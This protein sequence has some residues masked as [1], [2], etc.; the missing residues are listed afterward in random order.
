MSTTRSFV[1]ALTRA[2]LAATAVL[3]VATTPASASISA[4]TAIARSTTWLAGQASAGYISTN[5]LSAS[6]G[7]SAQTALALSHTRA[8][9]VTGTKILRYL[10]THA[11]ALAASL[12]STSPGDLAV[13]ILAANAYGAPSR[14]FGGVNLVAQLTGSLQGPT[15]SQPGLY[16]SEDPTYDGTYR[17]GLTLAALRAVAAPIPTSAITWLRAQE[18]PNGAFSSDVVANPCSGLAANYEGPDSNSTAAAIVGLEAAKAAVPSATLAFLRRDASAS[19]GWGFYPGD[20]ADPDSTALVLW[21]A[22]TVRGSAT[23]FGSTAKATTSLL[24]AA[25]PSGGFTYPGNTAPDVTST[26]QALQALSMQP[27]WTVTQPSAR[28]AITG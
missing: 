15:G 19:G 5:G 25:A 20:V 17:Q 3:A 9:A 21:A 22:A 7:Q 26:E 12:G 1:R 8:G 18:C 10:W 4:A 2:G 28:H 24:K 23:S 14:N 6:V 13:W 11:P 27:L 16:G